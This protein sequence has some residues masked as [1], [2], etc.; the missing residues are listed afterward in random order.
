M[1]T[2]TGHVW[3]DVFQAGGTTQ[4]W[5]WAV[6]EREHHWTFSFRPFQANSNAEVLRHWT[7]SDNNLVDTDHLLVHTDTGNIFRLSASWVSGS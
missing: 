5:F 3:S 7:T 4:E 2:G 1:S 6:G